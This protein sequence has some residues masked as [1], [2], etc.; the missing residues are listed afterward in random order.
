V[1]FING[2]PLVDSAA[3][4]QEKT[5]LDVSSR[6]EKAITDRDEAAVRELVSPKVLVHEGKRSPLIL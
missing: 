5:L 3:V 2:G 1:T 4:S 6:F